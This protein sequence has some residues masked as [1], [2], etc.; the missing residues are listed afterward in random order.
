[1]TDRIGVLH[2][3][4]ALSLDRP[5]EAIAAFAVVEARLDAV[6]ARHPLVYRCR[7][8]QIEALVL[9]GELAEAD[10]HLSR[11]ESRVAGIPTPWGLAVVARSRALAAAASGRLD[12]AEAELNTALEHHA[13]LPM[14]VELGR[15]LMLLG[16]VRRRQRR[17]RLASEAFVGARDAFASAGAARWEAAALGELDRTGFRPSSV[18]ALSP[19]EWEVARLAASGMTNRQV[20]DA[21]VLSPKTTDGALTRIY[22]KLGIHSRAELG[23]WI[24]RGPSRQRM[25]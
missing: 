15:T 3:R 21:M 9:A 23:A 10:A 14:P 2:S 16:R 22:T 19:T 7:G 25:G 13:D 17:K 5:R 20:A 4:I 12:A 18:D 24:A 8:D 6:G 11:F 1:M